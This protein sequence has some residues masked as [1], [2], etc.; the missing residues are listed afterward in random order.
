MKNVQ[1]RDIRMMFSHTVIETGVR[2]RTDTHH[3]GVTVMVRNASQ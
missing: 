3:P 2:S 1:Q